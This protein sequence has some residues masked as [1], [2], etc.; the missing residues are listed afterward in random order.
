ME[1]VEKKSNLVEEDVCKTIDGCTSHRTNKS[2][3]GFLQPHTHKST[4]LKDMLG[5]LFL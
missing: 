3:E 5:V 4:H 2:V 1:S